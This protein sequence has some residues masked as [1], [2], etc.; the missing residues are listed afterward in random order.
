MA[1]R[2]YDQFC[3]LALAL[4]IVG[5][6]WTLMI[7]R[8]LMSGPK[9]YSDLATALAGIGTSLLATRIKQLESDGVLERRYLR[10]PVASTVYEL[11]T[12]G[13][14]LAHALTPLA[15]WGSKHYAVRGRSPEQSFRAEWA[16]VFLAQ[17]FDPEQLRGVEVSFEFRA[18]GSSARLDI[19]DG[20]AQVHSGSDE[21]PADAVVSYD[22]DTLG[23]IVGGVLPLMDA[24]VQ[25]RV[26]VEGSPEAAQI[27]F[28]LLQSA[29]DRLG[30]GGAEPTS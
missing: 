27:L 25:Q 9:R 3:G 24:I 6:R 28:V 30:L 10:P 7:V 18:D 20:R 29:L 2:T 14:E 13:W 16:L 26:R 15:L 5:E 22:S 23:A 19:R 12:A 17:L 1:R 11:T 21:R 4:D 8:E